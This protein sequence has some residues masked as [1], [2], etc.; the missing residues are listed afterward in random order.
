MSNRNA[1]LGKM[2]VKIFMR[3]AHGMTYFSFSQRNLRLKLPRAFEYYLRSLK[4]HGTVAIG[5]PERQVRKASHCGS[6]QQ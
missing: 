1:L 4:L 6:K 2:Y 3:A 5:K